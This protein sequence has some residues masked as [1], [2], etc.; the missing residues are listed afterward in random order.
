MRIM[1]DA[2]IHISIAFFSTFNM[3]ALSTYIQNKHILVLSD[4]VLK[5]ILETTNRKFPN[6]IEEMNIYLNNLHYEYFI[7]NYDDQRKYPTIR[8]PNDLPILISAIQS[9]VD[10]FITGDKDF[11]EVNIDKPRILKPR[12]YQDEFMK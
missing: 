10:I 11:D 8:D 2:N 1:L 6:R 5:E 12:Q 7:S 9:Q 3:S 4:C